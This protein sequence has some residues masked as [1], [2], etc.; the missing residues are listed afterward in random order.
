METLQ[1]NCLGY[2]I[3]ADWYQGTRTDEIILF[4]MG[5]TSSK[6]RQQDIVEAI[7]EATGL[8]TLVID[9]TGHGDSPFEL[10]DIRPAQHLLESIT[11]YDWIKE[12][13]PAA[14]VSIVSASYGAYLAAC[15][16]EYRPVERLVLRVPAIYKPE[17][18]YDLWGD[19]LKDEKTYREAANVYRHD[20]PALE[21]HPIFQTNAKNFKGKA[22]VVAHSEDEL[23]PLETTDVYT[24]AFSADYYIAEGF[25]HAVSQSNVT[26]EQVVEY[27]RVISDWLNK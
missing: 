2:S 11:A 6:K 19:R 1:I 5:S 15:L 7:V 14:K 17:A 26:R 9:Y 16:I 21:A 20:V 3:A 25:K 23:F 18:L 24:K 10:K 8:S 12:H 4:L 27:Y 13:Y 22:F